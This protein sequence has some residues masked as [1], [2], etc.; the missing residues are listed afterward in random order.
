MSI[1]M[2]D[3]VEACKDIN[4]FA[5]SALS[6]GGQFKKM[7]VS[8]KTPKQGPLR[9]LQSINSFGLTESNPLHFDGLSKLME[10]KGGLGKIKMPGLAALISL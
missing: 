5:I 6:K 4:I 8:L 3:P 2:R 7:D 9:S 1:V 10:L